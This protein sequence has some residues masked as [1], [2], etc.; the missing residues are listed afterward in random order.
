MRSKILDLVEIALLG[1]VAALLCLGLWYSTENN[2]ILREREAWMQRVE[3]K[4][5]S[6]N[7]R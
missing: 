6:L 5:D 3:M 7:N 1:L 4:L 2:R